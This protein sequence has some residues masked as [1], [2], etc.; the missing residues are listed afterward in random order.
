[1]A[2]S[3]QINGSGAT[4]PT[5]RSADYEPSPPAA[6]FSRALTAEVLAAP[7]NGIDK[8]TLASGAA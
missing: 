1:M 7:A 3:A 8:V 4:V 5:S 6:F 2:L